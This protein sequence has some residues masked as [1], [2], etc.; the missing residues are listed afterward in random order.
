MNHTT[1][2]V[3]EE[4]YIP[5]AR[6]SVHVQTIDETGGWAEIRNSRPIVDV[7]GTITDCVLFLVDLEAAVYWS[8]VKDRQVELKKHFGDQKAEVPLSV[9][10]PEKFVK[11]K[12]GRL[13]PVWSAEESKA[14]AV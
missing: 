10:E 9:V 13:F 2:K 12:N 4:I 1:E 5:S 7:H 14:V 3:L 8:A 6:I 11:R